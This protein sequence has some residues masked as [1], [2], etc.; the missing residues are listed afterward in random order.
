MNPFESER[1]R[2][3]LAEPDAETR[4]AYEAALA[5][6]GCEVI[7]ALDGREALTK[8]LIDPPT[9]IVSEL[10]LP[11][12]DACALCDILRSDAATHAVPILIVTE[13]A[14][15]TELAHIRDLGADAVLVKPATP[16]AIL[17]EAQQLIAHGRNV[18]PRTGSGRGRPDTRR[19]LP[20]ESPAPP[21]THR[22]SLSKSH[23][24]FTTPA[25]PAAPPAL[26]C[27]SC[28]RALK[29]DRSH[30]GGVSNRHPEQWDYFTCPAC[31]TF[32]YR[33][34]TR[35]LRQVD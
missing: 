34:R 31:G 11:L 18:R 1:C 16:D 6:A 22:T 8:A 32:Q 29:Y 5:P 26:R 35:R 12:I 10:R 27:P 23:Q 17:I 24:R 14:R 7:E 13:E 19:E 9:L 30:V 25:P 33:Q 28:D 20:D 4:A 3:L 2:V 15:P 21:T